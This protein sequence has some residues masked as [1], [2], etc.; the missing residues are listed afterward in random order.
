M[1]NL[2]SGISN[3]FNPW[4]HPLYEESMMLFLSEEY[5]QSMSRFPLL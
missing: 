4:V 5:M 1:P 3:P 2:A